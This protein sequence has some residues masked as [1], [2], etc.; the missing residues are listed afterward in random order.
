[1]EYYTSSDIYI[2]AL[3]YFRRPAGGRCCWAGCPCP[4]RPHTPHLN[5]A[6]PAWWPRRI[7]DRRMWKCPDGNRWQRHNFHSTT[8]FILRTDAVVTSAHCHNYNAPLKPLP[9]SQTI[10]MV[11]FIM[12]LATMSSHGHNWI[13]GNH[14]WNSFIIIKPSRC[15]LAAI[16]R[17]SLLLL[18]AEKEERVKQK[19]TVLLFRERNNEN[20]IHCWDKVQAN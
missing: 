20:G 10:G 11:T 13:P 5:A 6:H 15:R 17:D 3:V 19:L 12:M 16:I 1:M 14:R 8:K 7:R 18:Q 2:I 4:L 9:P